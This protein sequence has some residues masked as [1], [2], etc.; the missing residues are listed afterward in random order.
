MFDAYRR[1]LE[2]MIKHAS[3][4]TINC[5]EGGSLHFKHPNFK[6]MKLKTFL[7]RYKR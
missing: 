3:V 7:R 2:E 5:T 1:I 6:C 4:K